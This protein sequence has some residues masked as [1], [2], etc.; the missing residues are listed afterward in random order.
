MLITALASSRMESNIA[1]MPERRMNAPM[2]VLVIAV[3]GLTKRCADA[4]AAL[5][6]GGTNVMSPAK[7]MRVGRRPNKRRSLPLHPLGTR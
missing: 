6:K 5:S 1:S 4:L 2:S 3:S 7:R